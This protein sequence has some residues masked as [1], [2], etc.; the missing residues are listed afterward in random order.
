MA[1][2]LATLTVLE[3][4]RWVQSA[5][6]AGQR[7]RELWAGQEGAGIDILVTP[8]TGML[9]PPVTW[10][11]W[12][13]DNDAHRARFSTFPNFAQPFNVSGQPA[14]SLPLGWADAGLPIGVQ[15]VGRPLEE[16]TILQ[17]AAELERA[18]PWAERIAEPARSFYLTSPPA[19]AATR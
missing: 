5:R 13:D 2:H 18:R 1:E 4:H 3:H 11:R 15:L 10:A 7:F 16:A 6:A 9:P 14:I 19:D 8:T 17:V 12:D